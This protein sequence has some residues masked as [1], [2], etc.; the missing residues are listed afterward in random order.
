M[1]TER[2]VHQ[3]LIDVRTQVAAIQK[4]A[5][6]KDHESAHIMEV[7]LFVSVLR[8]IANPTHMRDGS[9][10]AEVLAREAL[11]SLKLEFRRWF[12]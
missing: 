11:K 6:E 1:S 4:A 12:T 5:E 10:S 7:N 2:Y 8:R 3:D 9:P